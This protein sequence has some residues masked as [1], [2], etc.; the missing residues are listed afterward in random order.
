[1]SIGGII[2]QASIQDAYNLG[3]SIVVWQGTNYESYFAEASPGS[4]PA[5]L[6][7]QRIKVNPDSS[8]AAGIADGL[9][10][11]FQVNYLQSNQSGYTMK[12][13]IYI[14]F[15]MKTQHTMEILEEQQP[16]LTRRY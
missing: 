6:W 15:S 5:L 14:Y 10:K 2:V 16:S 12:F 11:L 8:F 4:I 7:N 1:M 13:F 3:Y 9:L